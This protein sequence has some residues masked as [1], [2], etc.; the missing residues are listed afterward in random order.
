MD[1]NEDF[2]KICEWMQ[3]QNDIQPAPGDY[4]IQL[5]LIAKLHWLNI[6]QKFFD[7]LPENLKGQHTCTS[8]LHTYVQNKETAK[9][10]ALMEILLSYG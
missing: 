9:A 2:C 10:E 3:Q 6:A 8:L 5:D 1:D 7:E 4:A